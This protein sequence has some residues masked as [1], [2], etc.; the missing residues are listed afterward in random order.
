MTDRWVSEKHIA[1]TAADAIGSSEKKN[2]L[3]PYNARES[4]SA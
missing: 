3:F 4:F 1:P 2:F